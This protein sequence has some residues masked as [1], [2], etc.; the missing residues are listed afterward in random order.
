[1]IL[2]FIEVLGTMEPSCSHFG[3]MIWPFFKEVWTMGVHNSRTRGSVLDTSALAAMLARV[4]DEQTPAD[5]VDFVIR[6]CLIGLAEEAEQEVGYLVPRAADP[7]IRYESL[8]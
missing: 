8:N 2:Y 3:C 4:V 6:E 5:E 1:M 7:R